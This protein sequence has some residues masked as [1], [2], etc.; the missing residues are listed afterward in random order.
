MI[1]KVKIK[2]FRGIKNVIL[3][4]LNK[5]NVIV[6][7]NGSGK[8]SLLDA[9]FISINPNNPELPLR[10]NVF[11]GM[12]VVD[13][14]FWKSF[15][16]DFKSD[17]NIEIVLN[18]SGTTDRK[19]RIKP[20]ISFEKQV[21]GKDKSLQDIELETTGKIDL[22]KILGLRVEFKVG[23]KNHNSEIVQTSSGVELRADHAYN[24]NLSGH[25]LNNLTY[26]KK[27]YIA[28]AFEEVVKNKRKNELLDFISSFEEN[29][30][31]IDF[32]NNRLMIDDK[33]FSRAVDASIY[34][35]G[36][37]RSIHIVVNVLAGNNGL[38]LLDEMENGLHWSKQELVWKAIQKIAKEQDQQIFVTTHSKELLKSLYNVS[39]KQGDLGL[40]KLFRLESNIEKGIQVVEYS[41]EQ[42]VNSIEG[43]YE[44]R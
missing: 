22:Q 7:D 12:S 16:Y 9:L 32:V 44:I 38:V 39:G 4:N 35:D 3:N 1:N 30:K 24:E 26:G 42:F 19:I 43:D 36:L 25:Y 13:D 28:S 14:D 41:Q 8:S 6:G 10:T 27:K 34:G 40:V 17:K 29:I 18:N 37:L 5:I 21:T 11:R 31:D 2:N 33:R 20:N 23:K 15:F